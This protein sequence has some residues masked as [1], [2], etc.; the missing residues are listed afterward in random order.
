MAVLVMSTDT[1]DFAIQEDEVSTIT[2]A[3][4]CPAPNLASGPS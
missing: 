4:L 2:A 1:G 3:E